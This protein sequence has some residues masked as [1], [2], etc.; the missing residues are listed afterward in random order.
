MRIQRMLAGTLVVL[1]G[2]VVAVAAQDPTKLPIGQSGNGFVYIGHGYGEHNTGQ[3]ALHENA[4]FLLP[5]GLK[6]DRSYHQ[7]S[8]VCCGGGA[9]TNVRLDQIPAGIY[10]RLDGGYFW[11]IAGEP[12]LAAADYDENNVVTQWKLE[13]PMYCGPGGNGQGCN[14]KVDVWA[15]QKP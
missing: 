8:W 14:M 2:L 3:G 5:R 10:I 4:E 12:I 15:K 9:T 1:L 7:A 6:L 11:A 13:V